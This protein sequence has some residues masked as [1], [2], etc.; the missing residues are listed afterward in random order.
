MVSLKLNMSIMTLHLYVSLSCTPHIALI[1]D[2]SA[3]CKVSHHPSFLCRITILPCSHKRLISAYTNSHSAHSLHL[4]HRHLVLTVTVP[5]HPQLL[6]KHSVGDGSD[7][8]NGQGGVP[9]CGG[10]IGMIWFSG[11]LHSVCS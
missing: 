10:S 4:V 1:T 2:L 5:V 11:H 9:L 6:Q 7:D 8:G 3:L